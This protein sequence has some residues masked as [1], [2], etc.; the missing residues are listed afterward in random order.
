[1]EK[2]E[3][4]RVVPSQTIKTEVGCCKLFITVGFDKSGI[5]LEV[6]AA[7]SKSG[8]CKANLEAVC[9]LTSELL[10]HGLVDEAVNHLENIICPVCKQ[11]KGELPKEQRKDFP[12]SCADAIA[13]FLKEL[14]TPKVPKGPLVEIVKRN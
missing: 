5:P 14:M 11:R 4:P 2:K 10:Q 6:F 12:N 13:K 7:S 3:R 9:R 8:G 1:M